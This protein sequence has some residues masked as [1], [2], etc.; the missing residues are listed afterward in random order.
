[1]GT[2]EGEV[3][4]EGLPHGIG[5]LTF[6]EDDPAGRKIYQGEEIWQLCSKGI[7]LNIKFCFKR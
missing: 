4:A 5:K 3:S 7:I 2:Y 6:N 1:M